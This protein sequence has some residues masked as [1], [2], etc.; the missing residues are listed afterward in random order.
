VDQIDQSG[1]VR[2]GRRNLMTTSSF[3]DEARFGAIDTNL[4]HIWVRK[5]LSQRAEW[6]HRR[7]NPAQQL[8]GFVVVHRRHGTSLLLGDNTSNELSNP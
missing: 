2:E 7:E 3:E 6:G 5:V 4:F 8:L 1:F